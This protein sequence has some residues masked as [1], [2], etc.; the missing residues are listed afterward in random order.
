MTGPVAPGPSTPWS[1]PPL[2]PFPGSDWPRYEAEIYALFHA[3]FLVTPT[4]WRGQPVT[5]QRDPMLNGKEDG[6]W[7]VMTETGPTGRPDDRMPNLDRCARIRWVKAVLAAPDTEVRVFGQMRDRHQHYGVALP[8]FS[9]IVFLRQWP[10]SVQ[11]KTAYH[12]PSTGK[13]D[14]YR[15][16]WEAD[17]R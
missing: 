9:Y 6:F 4:L 10:R 12:V 7:H 15:K 8:D 1:L 11:L 14:D 16:Q 5:I 17:K 3:D 2:V 13:Q